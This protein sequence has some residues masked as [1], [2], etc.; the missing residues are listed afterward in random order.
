MTIT[1]GVALHNLGFG[2]EHVR[3]EDHRSIVLDVAGS[4]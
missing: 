4:G 3:P 2:L 1:F